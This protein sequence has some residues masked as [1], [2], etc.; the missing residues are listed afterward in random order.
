MIRVC[1]LD[2]SRFETEQTFAREY[3]RMPA[4]RRE[5]ID[6]MRFDRDKRLSLGAGVLL[7]H[8]LETFGAPEEAEHIAFGANGKPCFP[9]VSDRFRF[10]LSHAGTIAL[11]AFDAG[12]GACP[13]G[14]D[15][16]RIAQADLRLAK[17]FFAE[18]EYA[19]LSG[20]PDAS[21]R[22]RAFFRLWTLKESFL[23]TTGDGLATPLGAF[24]IRPD[25]D[26]IR[27]VTDAPGTF[28]FGESDAVPGYCIAWCYQNESQ[29]GV[30]VYEYR[31]DN[32]RGNRRPQA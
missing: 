30:T 26:P 18:D 32:E 13:V 7:R 10:S 5:K 2:V 31:S 16:E 21:A 3:N 19:L 4:W 22:D 25:T 8:A 27:V 24:S 15:A 17:R 11:C 14:C 29:K 1:F 6:R 12:D 9:R 28:H 23:K 20:I